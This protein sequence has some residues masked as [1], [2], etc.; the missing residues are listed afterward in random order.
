[1]SGFDQETDGNVD[2]RSR[3]EVKRPRRFKVLLH[4]DHYTSMEFVVMILETVFRKSSPESL[5]IML[6][7]HQQGVGLAGVY[8]AA[9][10]ETKMNR[11]HV[12]AEGQGFPLKC[13]M[14]PE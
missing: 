9:V 1:M 4:N 11:V 5:E 12:E 8:P 13:S 2:T 3:D 14:E 7:V 10:A 6:S